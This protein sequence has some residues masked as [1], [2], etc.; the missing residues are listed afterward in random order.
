M[1][2][3]FTFLGREFNMYM[4]MATVGAVACGFVMFFR[5]YG[6]KYRRDQVVHI[7]LAA[8]A[9][10]FLGAHLVYFFTQFDLLVKIVA[11]PSNYITSFV[12]FIAVLGGLFGGMVFYGGLIGGVV[13]SWLYCRTLKLDFDL[14]ADAVA[15]G[16]PLFHAFGRIGCLCAGCCYG[17]ECSYGWHFPYSPTAD[18]TKTYFPI[19][20]VEACCNL[21]L[22]ILL[23]LIPRRRFPK[24]LLLWI[25]VILYSVERFI[26][27]FFRGDNVRGVF[28]TFSTSQWIS[29]VL[30]VLS[31]FMII[32]KLR[33][34]HV[35][36]E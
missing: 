18:P 8:A 17:F 10:A 35:Q 26:L 32:T 14:Y 16:V 25:Y 29:V 31:A 5:C 4:I 33:R 34:T 21:I 15:P 11:A 24:G 28:G 27:E 3:S 7:I 23:I 30:F 13:G 36:K 19:Q 12:D 2:Q 20:L 6:E 22:F 1:F 9:G